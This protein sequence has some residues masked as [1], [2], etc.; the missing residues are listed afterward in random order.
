MTND[1]KVSKDSKFAEVEKMDSFLDDYVEG[2]DLSNY[3]QPNI[4]FELKK[5]ARQTCRDIVLEIKRFGVS[6]RQMIYLIYL[7]SLELEDTDLMK[8]IAKSIGI[9]RSATPLS[10]ADKTSNKNSG[11]IL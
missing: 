11:L 1:D 4:E 2:M 7:L 5:E 3:V 8:L 6:Q 9:R 10:I